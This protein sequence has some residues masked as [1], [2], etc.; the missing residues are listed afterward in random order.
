MPP[1]PP[2]G[3]TSHTFSRIGLPSSITRLTKGKLLPTALYW[4]VIHPQFIPTLK[5]GLGLS[6]GFGLELELELPSFLGSRHF[7]LHEHCHRGWGLKSR[8]QFTSLFDSKESCISQHF[9]KILC[10]SSRFVAQTDSKEKLQ[11][12]WIHYLHSSENC[13][14]VLAMLIITTLSL[15]LRM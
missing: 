15:A 13:L 14:T 8:D 9:T 1:D 11:E 12:V 5:L 6:L 10:F 2:S 4:Y 3:R 7:R